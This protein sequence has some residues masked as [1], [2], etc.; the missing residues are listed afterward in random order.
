MKLT[1][2][3]DQLSESIQHVSKAISSRTTIPILS[4]IKIDA[5]PKGVMLTA[6]DTD[7]SIQSF[8]PLENDGIENVQLVQTGSVVL[9]AKFFMEMVRKLPSEQIEIEAGENHQTIIRSGTAEF[10][11]VGFD[12]E[13]Y[14]LLPQVDEEKVISM[15]SDLLKAMIK[16]TSFAVSTSET[17]PILTGVLW[18]LT[19]NNLKLI[20][21]DRH[22]LASRE[23]QIDTPPDQV[24]KSV[25]IS[26][27]TLSELNKILPDHNSLI[28][29]VFTETLV[30]FK[31][32]NVLFY[33]RVLEGVYPDTSKLIPQ[34]FQTEMVIKSKSLM[35]AIDRAYLL[36]REN[37]ANIVK[38]VMNDDQTI[39]IS[40]SSSDL[41]KVKEVLPVSSHSGNL[42]QISF[43]SKFMLDALKVIDSEFVHIGFTGPMNPI[44]I[45]PEDGTRILQLILPYRTTS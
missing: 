4:G 27:K 40:S 3:K 26:G 13:E 20:G 39:E 10:Q 30:L 33:T 7:I 23:S 35:D 32:S 38:L 43:N 18:S 29:I 37:K 34:Q 25:V 44:V 42:L 14:P 6:S 28:D 5:T 31:L 8:I 22:R 19:E 15:S 17:T 45:Q 11:L 9:P 41:G 16:Q 36:T 2:L 24:I 12:P 1:I 21:C